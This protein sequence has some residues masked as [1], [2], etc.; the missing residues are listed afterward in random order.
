MKRL[1]NSL[2]ARV[3]ISTVFLSLAAFWLAGSA[4]YNNLSSG[5]KRVKAES[6]ISAFTATSYGLQFD[7]IVSN[8]DPKRIKKA[9]DDV[10]KA[11]GISEN[12]EISLISLPKGRL[13]GKNYSIATD[14]ANPQL[15][16]A[17]LRKLVEK[18]NNPQWSYSVNGKYFIVGER[19]TVPQSGRYELYVYYNLANQE[20][21]NALI[22]R[23]L[24]LTGLSLL[25]LIALTTWLVVRQVVSPVREAARTAEMLTAGD[26]DQRMQVEGEDEIARL[27]SAFNEMADS[28]QKQ[29][30]RLENLSLVQQRFVSD[31]SH[32]LRTPL[33]TIRLASAVIDGAKTSFE[34]TVARS[35]QLLMSQLDRFERLLEDLL[36]ISR[37]DAEVA[38][39]EAVDFDLAAL[40]KSSVDE[41]QIAAKELK[42]EIRFSAPLQPVIIN[43]D[44]RRISRILRNLLTTAIDHANEK[45]IEVQLESNEVTVAFSVRDFGDGFDS[46]T[47]MR[48][49]DRFWRADPSR[50]RVHGGTGLGLSI[51]LEDARLHNG[52]L[53]AWAVQGKGAHFVATL[54][55]KAGENISGRIIKLQY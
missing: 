22:L 18:T 20:A 25:A 32:E 17:E 31:V 7:F 5:V 4:L 47:S 1:R 21:T 37:F 45:P 46:E 44:I 35:A 3:V 40:I 53:E 52:E 54:P 10:I 26:L 28:L 33:T 48:V 36:E 29:I 55:R 8:E 13:I 34:P 42:T 41:L 50:S 23:A 24:I 2:A 38:V 16:P 27:G 39:L 49:F 43:A 30:I 6:A 12:Q 15:I 14:Y 9:I 19:I 51:S 11:A